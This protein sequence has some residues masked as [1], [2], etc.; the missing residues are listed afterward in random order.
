[1]PDDDVPQEV[2]VPG[3]DALGLSELRDAELEVPS[4]DDCAAVLFVD[5]DESAD[6]VF[7][8]HQKRKKVYKIFGWGSLSGETGGTIW[9]LTF[10]WGDLERPSQTAA[11]GF[12]FFACSLAL[13][14]SPAGPLE[15]VWCVCSGSCSR[16]LVVYCEIISAPAVYAYFI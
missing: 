14:A 12:R 2:R 8:T 11:L 4:V 10:S 1:M 16:D 15:I 5:L 3:V 6:F 9:R 7:H 13:V